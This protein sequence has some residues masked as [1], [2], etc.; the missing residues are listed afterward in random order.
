MPKKSALFFVNVA[1]IFTLFI[2]LSLS[3]TGN[4][5]PLIQAK[6]TSEAIAE[7]LTKL[8]VVEGPTFVTTQGKVTAGIDLSSVSPHHIKVV[9]DELTVMLP[10]IR[11]MS[12]SLATPLPAATKIDQTQ[13]RLVETACQQLVIEKAREQISLQLEHL[14]QVQGFKKVNLDIPELECRLGEDHQ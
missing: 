3:L 11:I 10:P 4:L 12:V 13:N 9:N 7:Q 6:V 5:A 2:A 14:F 8:N 1:T